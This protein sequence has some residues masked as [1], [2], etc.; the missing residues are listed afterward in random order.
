MELLKI[1]DA[2]TRTY[3]VSGSED[4]LINTVNAIVPKSLCVEEDAIGNIHVKGGNGKRKI[5][6]DA[7][8][9]QIGFR[10]TNICEN[11]FLKLD[12]VGGIDARTLLSARVKVLVKKAVMG[13]FASVPP[14][15]QKGDGKKD[16]PTLSEL[17]LDIGAGSR[18]EAEKL[19]AIGDF[20]ALYAEPFMLNSTRYCSGALDNKAGCAVLLY[21]M[22]R[23]FSENS[24]KNTQVELILSSQEEVALR[25]ATAAAGK[26]AADACIVVDA[27]FAKAP[28]CKGDCLGS[29]SGGP[30][31]GVSPFLSKEL[32][33][34]L[35]AIAKEQSIP[36][37]LEVMSGATGTN[38]DA[39]SSVYNS[40]DCALISFPLKNMHSQSEIVDLRDLEAVSKIIESYIRKADAK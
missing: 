36:Y 35:C 10:V 28:G 3:S 6:L 21:V 37:T 25:G 29:L 17:S 8:C 12:A 32:T 30:M 19:C 14:H 7:H 1:L 15:L 20:A 13:V 5:L 40:G 9:D 18:K 38:A 16:F 23:L 27:S 22:D 4:S 34:S 39:L 2:L 31:I 11:G 26:I 33:D 24:L